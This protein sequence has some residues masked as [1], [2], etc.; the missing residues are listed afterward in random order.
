MKNGLLLVV[1]APAGCGK[2]TILEKVVNGRDIVYSV[3]CTTRAPRAGEKDGTHYHFKTEDEFK[4]LIEDGALLEYTVYC[5][6]YYGT[7]K[8]VVAD[9]VADGNCVVMKIEVEGAGNIKTLYPDCVSVFI[10]P[11]SIEELQSRLINR[12]TEPADAVVRRLKQAEEE[13]KLAPQYDYNIVNDKLK[14]AVSD[15]KSII[16]AEKLKNKR[17]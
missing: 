4:Q 11:P 12:G 17:V 3:S 16:R 14:T 6:N 2:D 10:L 13:I 9:A 15:L 1:S 5:G 7:L 8:S